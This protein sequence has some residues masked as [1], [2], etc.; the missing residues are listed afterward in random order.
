[1]SLSKQET[2]AVVEDEPGIHPSHSI[3]IDVPAPTREKPPTL[4]HTYAGL[5]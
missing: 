4:R 3:S 1:M 2:D 5:V